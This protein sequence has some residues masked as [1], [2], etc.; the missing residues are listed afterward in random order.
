M[1]KGTVYKI[2]ADNDETQM[3]YIGSTKQGFQN[4][5]LTIVQITKHSKMK[6][7]QTLH[8]HLYFLMNLAWIIVKYFWN[9][10]M[11]LPKTNSNLKSKCG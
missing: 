3:A 10:M 9:P 1:F 11:F 8:H 4:D 7:G 6:K 5:L 2:I